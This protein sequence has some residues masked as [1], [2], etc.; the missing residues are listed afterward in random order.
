MFVV[1]LTYEKP[2]EVIN[3][4]LVAHI[5]Y[6]NEQYERG[7]FLLSGP[8]VPRQGGVIMARAESREALMEILARD[9]FKRE[10][11]AR[12]DVIEFV[13]TMTAPVCAALTEKI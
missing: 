6:L 10:G 8:Q 9:P 13:A 2:L 3:E 7:V 4:L 12:Y 5:R 11:A 1:T